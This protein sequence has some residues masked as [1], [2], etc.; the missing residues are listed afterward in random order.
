MLYCKYFYFDKRSIAQKLNNQNET[1][2]FLRVFLKSNKV[3]SRIVEHFNSHNFNADIR[4]DGLYTKTLH[5]NF[6]CNKCGLKMNC[7]KGLNG[8]LYSY[9]K[10]PDMSCTDEIIKNILE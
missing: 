6:N 7:F 8:N 4:L 10:T 9:T 5:Y 2:I 3:H 1:N